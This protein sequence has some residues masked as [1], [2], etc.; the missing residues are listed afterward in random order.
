VFRI[1]YN[2]NLWNNN[3]PSTPISAPRLSN[4]ETQ[5]DDAMADVTSGAKDPASDVYNAFATSFAT[6][7]QISTIA[8]SAFYNF[9]VRPVVQFDGFAWPP[10]SGSLP[11]GYT[12]PVNYD[13]ADWAGISPPNDAQE[14]DRWIRQ[15][16]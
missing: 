2:R 6:A 15:A 3:D 13:S 1:P 8:N 14:G 7:E 10:R 16:T 9:G 5:Y 11:P 12:G 4:L